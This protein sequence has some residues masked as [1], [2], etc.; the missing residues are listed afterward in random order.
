MKYKEW[1]IDNDVDF[2]WMVGLLEGEGCFMVPAPS[3]LRSQVRID[4]KMC[5]KD[6]MDRAAS[7]LGTSAIRVCRT[8]IKP[9]YKD[10]YRIVIGGSKAAA[11]MRLILPYMGERR[12]AQ[13]RRAL[14]S[15]A[16]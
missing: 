11:I 1:A 14:D 10:I 8:N 12:S 9:S 16:D 15:L 13:I 3:Q 7:L 6:I 2:H 4:F 5:D